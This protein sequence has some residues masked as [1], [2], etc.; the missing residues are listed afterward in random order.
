[1]TQLI[2]GFDDVAEDYDVALVDLWGCYHDGERP[3]PE[4]LEAL[5]RYRKRGGRVVLL[6]NAP[7]PSAGVAEF[8]AKI[9]APED[10]HDAIMSS[11]EACQR[12]IATGRHGRRLHYVGPERDR[13]MLADLDLV[14]HPLEEASA[15]LLTGLRDDS[16]ERPEDYDDEAGRWRALGLS[17]VCANPDV[18]VDRGAT[19]LWCAGAVAER[20]AAA[21][22]QVVWYGKP[23]PPSY[24]A[25]FARLRELGLTRLDRDRVVAIGGGLKTDVAGA[26]RQGLDASIVTGG[27][28]AA[29]VG[30]DPERPDRDR[31][32]AYCARHGQLP[33]YAV[34]R[35][36]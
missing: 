29:E 14:S 18:V 2:A 31:L 19:R 36:R 3:Y 22:G 30:D 33:R 11:G 7:R 34:A 9:G 25:A 35:L 8:L 4:A 16:R 20:Y 23:H 12:A 13:A 24:E 32:R 15:V 6:P 17:V 21:G 27:I 1:M 5:R 28:A 10:T 26:N